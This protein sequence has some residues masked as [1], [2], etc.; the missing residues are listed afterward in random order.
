MGLN[1]KSYRI[2]KIKTKLMAITSIAQ[3]TPWTRQVALL[4]ELLKIET[5]SLKNAQWC[6]RYITEN[7]RNM[8]SD[9][10][11]IGEMDQLEELFTKAEERRIRRKEKKLAKKAA[12]ITPGKR[13]HKPKSALVQTPVTP[14]PSPMALWQEIIDRQKEKPNAT[15]G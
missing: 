10:Q 1:F 14:E 2:Q 13:G 15:E 7:M 12:G 4:H 6:R 5:I 11:T 8:Y 3:E 9:P